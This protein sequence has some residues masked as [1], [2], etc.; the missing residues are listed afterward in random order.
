MTELLDF[1]YSVMVGLGVHYFTR[2]YAFSPYLA[3][4]FALLA[5]AIL[6]TV[7]PPLNVQQID[8]AEER[9]KEGVR[10]KVITLRT[11]FSRNDVSWEA[12][13]LLAPC[14]ASRAVFGDLVLVHGISSGS[15]LWLETVDYLTTVFNVYL[16]DLPGWGRTPAP[17]CLEHET[18]P[19][20]IRDMHVDYLRGWLDAVHVKSPILVGHSFGGWISTM[21]AGRYPSMVRQLLLVSPHGLFPLMPIESFEI[22]LAVKYIPPQVISRIFGRLGLLLFRWLYPPLSGEDPRQPDYYYQMAAYSW[23]TGKGH[24]LFSRLMQQ[25]WCPFPSI[26]WSRPALET[27]RTLR[28]PVGLIW[29][30]K[31]NF[32]PVKYAYLTY[33]TRPFSD[34][35]ILKGS[36][37]NPAHGYASQFC[38][39]VLHSVAKY[40]QVCPTKSVQQKE[41]SH[42]KVAEF[43]PDGYK[44]RRVEQY[45]HAEKLAA[46]LSCQ[47]CNAHVEQVKSYWRCGCGSWSF[48]SHPGGHR[49]K[50]VV[51]SMLQFVHEAYVKREFSCSASPYLKPEKLPVSGVGK[52]QPRSPT[53]RSRDHVPSFGTEVADTQH[54]SECSAPSLSSDHTLHLEKAAPHDPVNVKGFSL[55]NWERLRVL[56]TMPACADS[57]LQSH[58]WVPHANTFLPAF[59][60]TMPFSFKYIDHGP[61]QTLVV[62]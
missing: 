24:R 26:W 2:S 32:V 12:H 39:A 1:A 27:F 11:K 7:V 52:L 29:G 59:F 53:T 25:R 20:A 44:V 43:E 13:A 6:A 61:G 45:Q 16:L 40:Q 60:R 50:E 5:F 15:A 14:R 34:L 54:S 55:E 30:D 35:Y 47:D 18:S 38:Q 3:V 37:H 41:D 56:P 62:E 46:P 51:D 22:S 9:L 42:G 19:D 33:K 17:D 48:N 36:D 10:S 57:A 4:I 21:F 49:T 31:D 23:W 28:M 58:S 8:Q